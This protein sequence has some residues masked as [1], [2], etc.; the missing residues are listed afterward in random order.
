MAVAFMI[1]DG[2]ELYKEPALQLGEKEL[3]KT[4]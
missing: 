2:R 4:T 1:A 3:A